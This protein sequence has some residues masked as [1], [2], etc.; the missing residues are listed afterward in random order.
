M[1]KPQPETPKDATDQQVA[2]ITKD[3][4]EYVPTLNSIRLI[5][6]DIIADLTTQ[7]YDKVDTPGLKKFKLA[8]DKINAH[9]KMISANTGLACAYAD[10]SLTTNI[11]QRIGAVKG[12]L[13]K[14]KK[15]V[16]ND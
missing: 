15:K 3:L 7:S 1:S 11:E 9:A 6:S 2:K 16:L 13:Q 12:D 5:I 4:E 8:L 10:S 14:F